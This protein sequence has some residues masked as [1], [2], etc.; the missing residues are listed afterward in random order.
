MHLTYR[1]ILTLLPFIAGI[2]SSYAHAADFVSGGG[3]P[4]SVLVR[5]LERLANHVLSGTS[6]ADEPT[7]KVT[8]LLGKED[9]GNAKARVWFCVRQRNDDAASQV[10]GND[11]RLIR[12]DSGLW[13]LEDE[14]HGKWIL[15]EQ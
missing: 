11:A 14:R 6:N 9:L 8:R 4:D 7:L 12:L 10:C 15:V 1:N 5:N 13:I 2:S 3:I